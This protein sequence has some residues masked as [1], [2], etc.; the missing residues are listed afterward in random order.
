[1]LVLVYSQTPNI[2]CSVYISD[3]LVNLWGLPR[4][5][6][7]STASPT[8]SYVLICWTQKLIT[9]W[10]ECMELIRTRY[11][12]D[13]D[14][15]WL[16]NRTGQINLRNKSTTNFTIIAMNSTS[17]ISPSDSNCQLAKW[18]HLYALWLFLILGELPEYAKKILGFFHIKKEKSA[19]IRLAA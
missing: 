17:S 19:K 11:G 8:F 2:N 5:K 18:G 3:F 9:I 14:L 1:M 7:T 6:C 15:R 13:H 16:F 4:R 10:D 12:N